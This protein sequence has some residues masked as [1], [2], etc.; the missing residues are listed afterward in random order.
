[1][2]E[3]KLAAAGALAKIPGD[4]AAAALTQLAQVRDTQLRRAAELSLARRES[5][6]TSGDDEDRDTDVS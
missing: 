4:A 1:M 5:W 3:L 2:R 6:L